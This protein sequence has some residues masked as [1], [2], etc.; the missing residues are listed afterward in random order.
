MFQALYRKWRPLVFSDVVG[1]RHITDTI[2][3]QLQ[4]GR[5]SHAYLFTGTRG[6]G[7]TTC[8]KILA[9]AVNCEHPVGGDPCNECPSCRG[10][11]SGSV[12]DVLELDAASNN[13]VENIR[14]IIDEVSY[15]PAEVKKRVYIID[16]VHMLS[17]SAFNALLKT[18][19]EPPEHVLFILATTEVHKVLPTILSRCQRFDFR[20]I[21]P[22]DIAARLKEVAFGEEIALSDEAALMIARLGDGSMR[23]ALSILERCAAGGENITPDLVTACMGI[24]GR[25]TVMQLLSAA[26]AFDLTRA[27]NLFA[28]CY[29]AGRDLYSLL[30][31]I[32]SLLRDLLILKTAQDDPFA[33]ID[34]GSSREALRALAQAIDTHRLLYMLGIMQETMGRLS[35][36]SVRRI[37][38]ELCLI[39][40]CSAP[41]AVSPVQAGNAAPPAA[42][43]AGTSESTSAKPPAQN[44]GFDIAP[45]VSDEDAPPPKA[46]EEASSN[47][48]PSAPPAASSH[49][50]E[51][52]AALAD[53]LPRSAYSNLKL[54]TG[55]FEASSL[56]IYA[57]AVAKMLLDRP[58]VREA[59]RAAA[60]AITGAD[61]RIT[62]ADKSARAQENDKLSDLAAIAQK[63]NIPVS[64]DEP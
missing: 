28:E 31:E 3:S 20:R 17:N 50:P 26:A 6:T 54:C 52:V 46:G 55:V 61:V 40:L 43:S 4:S 48:P 23:D 36:V 15:T 37:D 10:I 41:T 60:K 7:K 22:E 14:D 21:R 56:C 33:L 25:E 53:K 19:E 18:L 38:A 30:D 45:P 11:L 47:E 44:E 59:I 62:F 16:E 51:L 2:K 35:R 1:Q 8:A 34:A 57:D 29:Q 24:S 9:R 42:P 32:V 13:K 49:W 63:L 64:V 12:L 27:L 5:L 39:R 58:A